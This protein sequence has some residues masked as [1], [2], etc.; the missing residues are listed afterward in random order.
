[1][2]TLA[3]AATSFER[4]AGQN[5]GSWAWRRTTELSLMRTSSKADG[6]SA[7]ARSS[8]SFRWG[9][10]GGQ[11]EAEEGGQLRG[12]AGVPGGVGELQ[13]DIGALLVA[14]LEETEGPLKTN[15]EVEDVG[16]EESDGIDLGPALDEVALHGELSK[17]LRWEGPHDLLGDGGGFEGSGHGRFSMVADRG[18]DGGQRRR[19][20]SYP[21]YACRFPVASAQQG[22]VGES[23]RSGRL[24]R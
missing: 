8:A 17:E 11:G 13:L 16:G 19:T 15:P 6:L 21:R 22:A 12:E 2:S 1:M 4:V 10:S 24:T 20:V 18:R 3:P 23:W 14:L 5:G 7:R 9:G